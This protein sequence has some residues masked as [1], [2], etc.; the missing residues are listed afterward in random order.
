LL[1][2]GPDILIVSIARPESFQTAHAFHAQL[3][4]T[5]TMGVQIARRGSTAEHSLGKRLV[6]L[7]RLG[8]IVLVLV[9]QQ[10]KIFVLLVVTDRP[11]NKHLPHAM[12]CVH[13]VNIALLVSPVVRTV[14]PAQWQPQPVVFRK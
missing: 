13:W 11:P 10:M 9:K 12:D 5:L 14:P 1:D 7:V 3:V 2:L 8:N 6:H 4:N